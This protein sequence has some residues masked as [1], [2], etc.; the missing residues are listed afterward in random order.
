MCTGSCVKSH[1]KA[2]ERGGGWVDYAWKNKVE[3]DP[4]TKIAFI[5][6]TKRF[7]IKYYLGVGFNH[8][9]PTIQ[10][11]PHCGGCSAGS[12]VR[13]AAQ[14]LR[15]SREKHRSLRKPFGNPLRAFF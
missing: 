1:P 6:G 2:A 9:H 14:R 10:K 7:G 11:A 4:F 3:E 12:I 8:A 15:E 13:G 5:A